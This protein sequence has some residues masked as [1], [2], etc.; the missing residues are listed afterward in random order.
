MAYSLTLHAPEGQRLIGFDNAHVV[1]HVGGRHVKAP[2]QADH[3]HRALGDP[4][5]PYAFVSAEQLLV[6]FFNEV[7]RTLRDLA[8]QFVAIA[9]Q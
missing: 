6:D 7:E 1:P 8:L 3:W 9:E 4:G 5:R 2:V